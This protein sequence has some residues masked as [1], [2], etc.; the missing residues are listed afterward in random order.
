MLCNRQKKVS[1][2]V[3]FLTPKQATKSHRS[4][5]A[6][7]TDELKHCCCEHCGIK[8]ISLFLAEEAF[9]QPSLGFRGFCLF[10]LEQIPVFICMLLV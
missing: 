10:V 3:I 1:D 6:E 4:S 8:K 5:Q 2:F 7:E 9:E